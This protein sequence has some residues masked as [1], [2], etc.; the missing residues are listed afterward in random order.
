MQ[1]DGTAMPAGQNRLLSGLALAEPPVMARDGGGHETG[2]GR[3]GRRRTGK[4]PGLRRFPP[5][6]ANG[7]TPPARCQAAASLARIA[8]RAG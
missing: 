6:S 8:R 5:R 2:A 4:C 1:L 3:A 7:W